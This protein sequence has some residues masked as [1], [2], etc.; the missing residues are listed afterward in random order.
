M[1]SATRLDDAIL[2]VL[3]VAQNGRTAP[4]LADVLD[5]DYPAVTA[6]LHR[7]LEAGLVG[8]SK[9]RLAAWVAA[10]PPPDEAA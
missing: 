8:R 3:H 10:S 6:A 9:A 1:T 2:R 7:L 4:E 5:A